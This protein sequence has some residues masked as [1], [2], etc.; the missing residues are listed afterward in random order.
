[1]RDEKNADVYLMLYNAGVLL[2][3]DSN[4]TFNPKSPIKR[5]EISAIINRVALPENRVNGS[6]SAYWSKQGNEYDLEFNGE[7]CPENVVIGDAESFEVKNGMLVLKP[8][9]R[10]AEKKPQFDPKITVNDIVVDSDEFTKLKV[11][12]KVDLID[13]VTSTKFDFYFA[14]EED[15]TFDEKKAVHQDFREFS[16]IDPAGWYVMEIDLSTH[17]RWKG[18]ITSFRFD[19]AN[20]NGVYTLDYIRLVKGDPLTGASHEKLLAEGYTATRLMQDEDFERG[21]FI[22]HYEKQGDHT[23]GKWQD[24]CETDADPLW[25]ILPIWNTYDLVQHRD[26]STDKYTLKDDKGINT[27]IYN[28]EEKSVSMRLDAT[29]IYE[30]KPHDP[31]NYTWWPHLLLEQKSNWCS[32]D[33]QRNTAAADRMFI[34]LDAKITD[35]K[36]TTNT[37][38]QNVCDFLIYFYL[39]TDKAPGEKIWFGMSVFRGADLNMP[40]RKTGW[41]PDSA[42]NQYMYGIRGNTVYDGMENSFNYAVGKVLM[43][44][45]KHV[46]LDVTQHLKTAVEWA[47]RDNIFGIPVTVED[48]YISGVNIGYEVRGNF[49]CTVEFKNFNMISYNK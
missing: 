10:G 6:I 3:S 42:A 9:D 43:N 38:G 23:Y 34:E 19:P 29:K 37:E 17:D 45:W 30:G 12:M 39:Q 32:F 20:T 1:M 33:K 47:N 46:R 16:Y 26:T 14:T 31:E 25:A 36:P 15:G 48:M 28:P 41:S 49:D 2:G 35:F 4:G 22:S 21:F 24:Y 8:H 7:T 27:I 44:E 11:R 13:P 18:N 5:S 40:V